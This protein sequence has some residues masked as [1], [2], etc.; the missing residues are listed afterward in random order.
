MIVV[1]KKR[2]MKRSVILFLTIFLYTTISGQ[3]KDKIIVIDSLTEQQGNLNENYRYWYGNGNNTWIDFRMD[4]IKRRL[5]RVCYKV[6]RKDTILVNYYFQNNYLIKVQSSK[7]KDGSLW[8]IGSY[9]YEK[10]DLIHKKGSNYDL[11]GVGLFKKVSP[12]YI[13]KQLNHL[14]SQFEYFNLTNQNHSS[15]DPVE[16]IRERISS[17][18]RYH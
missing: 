9:Y 7:I 15:N 13:I 18:K 14:Y 12:K 5:I 1:I 2:S 4:S 10:N 11:H 6:E 16:L 17:Q 8:S 3:I